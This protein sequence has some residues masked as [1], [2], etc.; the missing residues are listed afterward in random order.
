MWQFH[1]RSLETLWPT[2]LAL[3]NN[4]V[5]MPLTTTELKDMVFLVQ[6]LIHR[7]LHF[8]SFTWNMS[9]VAQLTKVSTATW[10]SVTVLARAYRLRDSSIIDVFPEIGGRK[11]SLNSHRLN[12]VSWGITAGTSH[13][14]K[15]QSWP[16]FTGCLREVRKSV[17]QEMTISEISYT[18]SFLIN[19]RLSMESK[20]FLKSKRITLTVAPLPLMT[21]L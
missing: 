5:G 2:F 7:S 14:F 4:S 21:P 13:H 11:S 20:A 9:A 15:R 17:I 3:V 8:D 1:F 6:K 12:F 18:L 19:I 10:N 16:S